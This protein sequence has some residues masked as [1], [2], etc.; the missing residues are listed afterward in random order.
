MSF[1]EPA[2]LWLLLLV[3]V[4]VVAY[5][6]LQWRRKRYA[7]RFTNLTLLDKVA[8]RRPAWRRHVAAILTMVTVGLIVTAFAQPQAEVRVPRER[9]TI[10]LTMDIS[11]SMMS[12]DVTPTRI[13]AAQAAAKKFVEGLPEKYNVAFVTFAGTAQILVPPTTDHQSVIRAIDGADLA[14]S[15]ATGEAIF[16]SLEALKQVP[17][18]PEHPNDPPPARIVLMSDGFR[19]TGRSVESGIAA[20]Q[21]ANVPIYTI[22]FGTQ[23]GTV[24][25]DGQITD[26]PVDLNT[27][28]QIADQTDGKM[29]A[30]ESG[31]QLSSAYEDIGSSIGYTTEEREITARWIG[32]ALLAAL[33]AAAASLLF[34]GRLP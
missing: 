29:F 13:K 19:N 7:L 32:F 15:T 21:R 8:P 27:M 16:T 31:T 1:V 24:E 20:A 18:D 17:A 34:L 11:L 4:L 22:G 12:D 3:P 9:A 2:R 28:Q 26:V 6:L 30:A 5:A 33:A 23:Y 14:E 25:I 10:V